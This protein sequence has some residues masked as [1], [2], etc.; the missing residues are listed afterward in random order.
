MQ[1]AIML[2]TKLD[3]GTETSGGS[4]LGDLGPPIRRYP[5]KGVI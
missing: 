1:L 2:D 4:F 3:I 5:Y